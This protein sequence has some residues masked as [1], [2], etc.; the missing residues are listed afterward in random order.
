MAPH[1][2]LI[3]RGTQRDLPT[4]Q[5]ELDLTIRSVDVE[6]LADLF[7]VCAVRSVHGGA[8]PETNGDATIL[9]CTVDRREGKGCLV[10]SNDGT[11]ESGRHERNSA[12]QGCAMRPEHGVIHLPEGRCGAVL[13][14]GMVEE[15]GQV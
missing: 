1:V 13:H 10:L 12:C 4:G 7:V 8:R 14:R 5:A 3:W 6:L 11:G 2:I 15:N 9:G